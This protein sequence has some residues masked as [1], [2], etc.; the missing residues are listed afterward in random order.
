MTVSL[1]FSLN[2]CS[3][4]PGVILARRTSSFSMGSV[5]RDE[6]NALVVSSRCFSR[7]DHRAENGAHSHDYACSVR[8]DFIFLLHR[9]AKATD[10]AGYKLKPDFSSHRVAHPFYCQSVN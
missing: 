7:L 4:R 5:L 2:D 6:V 3:R 10:L 9:I 8:T 1:W